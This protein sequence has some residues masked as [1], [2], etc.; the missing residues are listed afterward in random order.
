MTR[1]TTGEGSRARRGASATGS[2]GRSVVARTGGPADGPDH[3]RVPRRPRTTSH[4]RAPLTAPAPRPVGWASAESADDGEWLVRAVP[5]AAAVKA[6]RC[7]GCDQVIPPGTAHV[8]A[9]PAD[10]PPGVGPAERR[11]WHRSC[12]QARSRRRPR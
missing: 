8:V 3:G 6:Y 1:R 5:G 11:H 9:W 4:R 7:P 2:D 10:A 12:W